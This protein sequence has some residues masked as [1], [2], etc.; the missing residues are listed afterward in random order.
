MNGV[1][2]VSTSLPVT[3]L[4]TGQEPLGDTSPGREF[5]DRSA[6][7]VYG[8]MNYFMLGTVIAIA[9][10]SAD[11]VLVLMEQEDP[12]VADL[13]RSM[14]ARVIAPGSDRSLG[15]IFAGRG[16]VVAI[17]GDGTHDPCLIPEL[18]GG[19][20]DGYDAS[21]A[22]APAGPGHG[23]G[24]GFVALSSR[25][26]RGMRLRKGESLGQQMA[27]LATTSGFRVQYVGDGRGESPLFRACRIGVV[28][29]AYNEELLLG[30]TVGGIPDYV[31]KIY[32]IDDCST[33]GTP[34]VIAGLKDPRVVSLRHEVNRGVGASIVDGYKM[35]L[36]DGMDVVAVM[37]GDNQMDPAELSRL[38]L[39]VLEGKADYAKG[40]RL[41]SKAFRKGM[42]PW[43]SLG[44]F[45]LTMITKIGSGYWDIMDPQN[46]YTAV[47]RQALL[48]LD[49]D[50]VYTYYG[51]CNDLLIKMNARGM[52]VTDVPIPARYGR[53]RSK[54]RYGPFILKVA[55]MIFRGFL[56]RLK[57]KYVVP[58]F[59]PLVLFYATGMITAPAG[60]ILGLL[61]VAATVLNPAAGAAYLLLAAFV[62]AAGLQS[63]FLGMLLDRQELSRIKARGE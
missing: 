51:Y 60:V 29:P 52:R 18:L 6:V 47:S 16:P 32:V 17:R 48:A 41:V 7:V 57:A 46:G 59:H 25:A 20:R 3:R 10:S 42:S 13:A 12:R 2:P 14:G 5:P 50:S 21:I 8:R 39:P 62:L 34:S 26:A 35:A 44:N 9:R 23:D 30:E 49:L 11:E 58:D 63:L 55:P 53:E 1:G 43:R 38:L 4:P 45:L 19:I 61:A 27:R 28:V 31:S 54:I 56:W 33:D 15:L 40:N 22:T 24:A 36:A 37:A